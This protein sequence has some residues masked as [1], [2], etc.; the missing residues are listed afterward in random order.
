MKKFTVK[1]SEAFTLIELLVVI[2]IIAILMSIMMPA[3]S[4][5]R[6]QAQSVVCKTRQRDLGQMF[7]LY[8]T[9]YDN[10]V[11][12]TVK[13]EGEQLNDSYS[14]WPCRLGPY[15]DT[16]KKKTSQTAEEYASIIHT[17]PILRCPSQEKYRKK[18][19][20]GTEISGWRGT[21]GMN[22]F[23]R[24]IGE[25]ENPDTYRKMNWR[26]FDQI[27]RPQGLPFLAEL[28]GDTA[29]WV[30]SAIRSSSFGGLM[31]DFGGPH[32]SAYDK[33]GWGKGPSDISAYR[34]NGPAPNHG[35]KSNYLFA[36][37][38]AESKEVWPWSDNIGT[39]FH[40][41]RNIKTLP[42]SVRR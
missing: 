10:Q 36:D 32:F 3:L 41:K 29:E 38:H 31:L 15:Y 5:A 8:A 2:S 39:D 37:G 27:M 11:V 17:L 40:P 16:D 23:F 19:E 35:K 30:P 9:D 24:G 14:R 4:K 25:N 21:F 18:Y 42:P 12:P 7:M 33:A 34:A 22:P 6:E 28:S 26:K 20:V 1:K 13:L